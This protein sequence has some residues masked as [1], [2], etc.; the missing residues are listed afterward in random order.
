M[1]GR[2]SDELPVELSKVSKV[3]R[4]TNNLGKKA[5]QPG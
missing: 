4:I 5:E 3:V 2:I 1:T